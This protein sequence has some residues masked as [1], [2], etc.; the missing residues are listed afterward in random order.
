MEKERPPVKSPLVQTSSYELIARAAKVS[1]ST[2]SRVMRNDVR[3]SAPTAARVREAAR[4]LGYRPNPLLATL[5]ERIRSGRK[6]SYQGTI[7]VLT[8]A[9]DPARW[10]GSASS[11][12]DID[13]GAARRA[14]ERGYRLEYFSTKPYDPEGRRLSQILRTRDIHGL[15]VAPGFSQRQLTL[16]WED[17]SAATTGYGLVNPALHRV[18]Y[19]NYHGIQLACRELRRL[20]YRRIGLYLEER[21]DEVTDHN[22]L[23]GFLLYLESAATAD[24]VRPVLVPRYQGPAFKRWFEKARPDAVI[25]STRQIVD[26]AREV[27]VRS[28][29]EFGFVHL[30]HSERVPDCAGINHSSELI[31]EAVIDLVV[32]QIHRGETGIPRHAMTTVV[33]G[34]WVPGKSVAAVSSA[35]ATA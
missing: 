16:Q 13:R 30:D 10:Y 20:G 8:E 29:E 33:E 17:F 3:I 22:Y 15:Y 21:N 7:G 9:D 14:E 24:R 2:V 27:G 23:A 6:L 32:A 28:P 12:R 25:S 4:Q 31:G 18:C 11:W 34:Y 5:M 1:R 35:S 26:W 19:N